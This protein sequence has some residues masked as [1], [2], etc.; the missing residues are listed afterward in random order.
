MARKLVVDDG[1]DDEML[2]AA[3][4]GTKDVLRAADGHLVH[5]GAWWHGR[6]KLIEMTKKTAT[7]KKKRKM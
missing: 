1:A 2:A 5:S 6:M 3:I 7:A 4:H